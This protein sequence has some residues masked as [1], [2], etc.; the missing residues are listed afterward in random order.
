MYHLH[1]P[2]WNYG[3]AQALTTEPGPWVAYP[4]TN[5]S[6]TL[7]KGVR[8][9]LVVSVLEFKMEVRPEFEIP[10]SQKGILKTEIPASQI[11]SIYKAS[12]LK[13]HCWCIEQTQD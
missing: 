6:T 2:H 3:C 4:L 1:L 13:V 12:K 10:P 9:G 11:E 5:I 7:P 8:V